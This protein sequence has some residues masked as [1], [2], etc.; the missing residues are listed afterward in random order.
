MINGKQISDLLLKVYEGV[1][2]DD[3]LE[4][5][6]VIL[7]GYVTASISSCIVTNLE[8]GC[9]EIKKMNHLRGGS[10]PDSTDIQSILTIHPFHS[11]FLS[12]EA[13]AV[14]CTSDIMSLSEWKRMPVYE[15]FHQ[16]LGMLYDIS[17][18]FYF[19]KNCISFM[20]TDSCP[21]STDHRRILT[22]IAPHLKNAYGIHRRQKGEFT[23]SFPDTIALLDLTGHLVDCNKAFLLLLEKYFPGDEPRPMQEL[24]KAVVTWVRA[25]LN[26]KRSDYTG[27]LPDKLCSRKGNLSLVLNLHPTNKGVLLSLEEISVVRIIDVLLGF[28][29][30]L[31]EAEVMSWVAQ[32]KQNSEIAVILGIR[33]ATVRKHMEHVLQKLNCETRGSA[34]RM[35]IEVISKQLPYVKCINCMKAECENCFAQIN[36]TEDV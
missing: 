22:L 4:Y 31:R 10:L 32:G 29:L 6:C 34:S 5:L 24:P 3:F 1:T 26:K 23:R 9:V 13:G 30:T 14:V 15:R 8:T 36:N 35:V 21:M 18:R 20:F 19:G 27:G 33:T 17:V 7:E 16:P 28:G 25:V 2:E 11:C 12:N